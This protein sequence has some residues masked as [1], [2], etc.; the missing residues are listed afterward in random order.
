[1]SDQF[2]LNRDNLI[3]LVQKITDTGHV[4]IN[5]SEYYAIRIHD[6]LISK[7]SCFEHIAM[8]VHYLNRY[9][10]LKFSHHK[11]INLKNILT[12]KLMISLT[13]KNITFNLILINSWMR[14]LILLANLLIIKKTTFS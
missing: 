3:N 2:P 14:S 11:V 10:C 1:M 4:W 9:K 5:L 12:Y 8:H 13:Q 7:R 6:V